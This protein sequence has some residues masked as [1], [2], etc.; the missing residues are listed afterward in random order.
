MEEQDKEQDTETD[1][2]TETYRKREETQSCWTCGDHKGSLA[3]FWRPR[4]GADTMLPS[5]S[6]SNEL[7]NLKRAQRFAGHELSLLI[8]GSPLTKHAL[9]LQALC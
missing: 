5:V 7:E 9:P 2:E 8:E 3:V 6:G 4:L 1:N